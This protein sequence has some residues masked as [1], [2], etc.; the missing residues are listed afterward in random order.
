MI[1]VDYLKHTKELYKKKEKIDESFSKIMKIKHMIRSMKIHI[2]NKIYSFKFN[3]Y[4]SL[5]K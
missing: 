3:N 1:I 4:Y 2:L 5:I